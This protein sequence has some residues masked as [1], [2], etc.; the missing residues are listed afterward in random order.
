MNLPKRIDITPKQLDAI[1]ARAKR[2]LPPDDYE[3]I[4]GMADTIVFL[5]NT[6]GKKNA[7]VQKLLRM[8]FGTVTEKTR[9][10]LKEK[11]DKQPE[12]KDI[13]GHGRNGVDSYIG[14]DK[15]EIAHNSLKEK[16]RCPCCGKGKLYMAEPA[17][18]VRV[19][20]QAPLAAKVY[21]MARLRCNLCG[22]VFTADPPQG[23]GDEKYDAAA[24][25]MLALLKYGSGVPFYR[26][27]SLKTFAH[28]SSSLVL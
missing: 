27:D 8:L 7:Q 23:I 22:K 11:K 14:A 4:R 13:K 2:L 21:E 5:S 16:D 1:L 26:L 18:L 12:K 9:K 25:A 17:T 19:T 15:I 6:V 10:V 24:G 3:I 28:T 20:G